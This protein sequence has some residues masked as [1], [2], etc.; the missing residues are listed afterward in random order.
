MH[1][2]TSSGTF[3]VVFVSWSFFVLP[4]LLWNS[5]WLVE[6]VLTLLCLFLI[7]RMEVSQF[8]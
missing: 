7:V 2:M 8:L 4:F 6:E 1:M 5:L 3:L